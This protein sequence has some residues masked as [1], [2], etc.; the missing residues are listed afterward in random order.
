VTGSASTGE[1]V[2]R[3]ARTHLRRPATGDGLEYRR[4]KRESAAFLAPWEPA[5]PPG[6]DP[7]GAL[8]FQRYLESGRDPRCERYLL[9]RNEDGALLGG[10]NVNEIV[11][12][13]F[14]SAYLGYWIGERY[15]RQGYMREGLGLLLGEAFGRLR[16]HRLE[17]NIRPENAASIALVRGAG[18][19][20]EGYSPRYLLIAG[21]WRDHE[22]WAILA[23]EWR[24]PAVE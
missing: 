5:S 9:A 12:G 23:E 6:L 22:R 17:A 8:M 19:R 13:V 7:F 15:A 24:E 3:G 4:L 20:R 10:L 1:V 18:F 11:R 21:D 16:L 2:A 14:Q